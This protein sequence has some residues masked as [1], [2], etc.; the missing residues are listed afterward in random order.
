LVLWIYVLVGFFRYSY[1]LFF[2]PNF[3]RLGLS[4][5]LYANECSFIVSWY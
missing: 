5:H 4:L 1:C 2:S 3:Q